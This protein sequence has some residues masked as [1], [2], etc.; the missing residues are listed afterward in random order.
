MIFIPNINHLLDLSISF[1][2]YMKIFCRL[3]CSWGVSFAIQDSIQC[4]IDNFWTHRLLRLIDWPSVHHSIRPY[5]VFLAFLQNSSKVL[6]NFGMSV[7][8]NRTHCLSKMFFLEK[9]LIT[10]DRVLSI[11]KRCVFFYFF[12]LFFKTALWIFLIFCISVEDNR[13]RWSQMVFL[14]IFLIP[15]LGD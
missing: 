11:Q 1:S 5:D 4:K 8:D 6:P 15:D 2:K 3:F 10:V 7:E 12:G 9:N 13:A 14:K